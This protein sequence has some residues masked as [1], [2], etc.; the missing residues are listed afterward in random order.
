MDRD[1]QLDT[2]LVQTVEKIWIELLSSRTSS[3]DEAR[4]VVR[5]FMAHED[6]LPQSFSN[7]SGTTSIYGGPSGGD[8]SF[9]IRFRGSLG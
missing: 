4:L 8:K 5:V 3:W 7:A 1:R 9:Q 2:Q 6:Q